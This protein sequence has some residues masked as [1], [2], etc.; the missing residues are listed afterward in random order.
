MDILTAKKVREIMMDCLYKEEEISDPNQPPD[1]AVLI[2]GIVT[3]YALHP[4]RLKSHIEEITNL[5][6]ELPDAFQAK[7]GG[8]WTFLNAR[9]DKHGNQWGQ[10]Q[11]M[12]AL[13]CLGIG[14]GKAQWL[15]PRDMWQV[16]PGGMPYVSIDTITEQEK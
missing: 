15:L 2:D 6:S 16:F 12:E 8:G 13:F 7:V 1:G 10:H 14:I 5:L 4:D 11:D 9:E 3:K